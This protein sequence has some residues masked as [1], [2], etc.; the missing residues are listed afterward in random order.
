VHSIGRAD[1]YIGYRFIYKKSGRKLALKW[2]NQFIYGVISAFLELPG[3][4][5]KF[6]VTNRVQDLPSIYFGA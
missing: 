2:R 3:S 4:D 5:G 6:Q 1:F